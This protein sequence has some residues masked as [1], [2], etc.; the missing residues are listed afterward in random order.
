MSVGRLL[1]LGLG[2][3]FSDVGFLVTLG[4]GTAGTPPTPPVPAATD[5]PSNWQ[6][7]YWKRKSKKERDED[8]RR[9]RIELGILPPDLQID[10]E[11]AVIDAATAQANH[12]AGRIDAPDAIFQQMEARKQY[13][14]AYKQAYKDAY[15][16]EVVAELW[17]E[18]M[19]IAKKARRR[20]LAIALLLH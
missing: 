14:E 20:K 7:D 9:Q 10:A 18:D 8:E 3:P 17:K 1:T 5:Q 4:L 16:A 11:A 2:T 15:I 13:E 19:R 6:A 12:A